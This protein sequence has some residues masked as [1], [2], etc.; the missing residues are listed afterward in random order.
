[1]PLIEFVIEVTSLQV[2]ER[3]LKVR[4]KEGFLMNMFNPTA[5][6]K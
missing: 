6:M 5:Q 3:M 2:Q 1:M 4:I